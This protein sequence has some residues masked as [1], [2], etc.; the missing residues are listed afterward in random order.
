MVVVL[1]VIGG[2]EHKAFVTTKSA[3]YQID[4]D[5]QFFLEFTLPLLL[6]LG[7]QVDRQDKRR[8]GYAHSENRDP[9]APEP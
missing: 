4:A 9:K 5:F 7:H 6:P 3:L 2:E 8:Y 1:A